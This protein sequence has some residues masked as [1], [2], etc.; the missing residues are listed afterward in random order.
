MSNRLHAIMGVFGLPFIF[1]ILFFY[2][3]IDS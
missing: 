2:L 1:C 3:A